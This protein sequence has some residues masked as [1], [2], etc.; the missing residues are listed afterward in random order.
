MSGKIIFNTSLGDFVSQYPQVRD[1][2]NYFGLDYCFGGH[3][4]VIAA[5][6]EKNVELEE[7][8]SVIQNIVD[9]TSDQ[10]RNKNWKNEPL[11][12]IINHVE[13]DHHKFTWEKL[14]SIG[15]VL[16]K[17]I[18]VH[19]E[20]NGEFLNGLKKLFSAFREKLEAHLRIEEDVVFSY[21]KKLDASPDIDKENL[22]KM[23]NFS[24][25][26]MEHLKKEHYE[27]GE[28]FSQIK[29]F[30]SNYELPDF[31]CAS[32]IKLYADLESLEDDLRIHLHLE[33]SL[34]FPMIMK[35]ID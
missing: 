12:D 5:A 19:G 7:Y 22:A 33:D 10:G 6:R 18:Q 25:Q 27:I 15:M 24:N 8:Q 30:T 16:D 20:K 13:K 17:I 1:M 35:L 14:Y 34:L 2:L 11:K 28:L 3:R 32:C 21:V 9:K 4:N 29:D 26:T 23:L 31:A